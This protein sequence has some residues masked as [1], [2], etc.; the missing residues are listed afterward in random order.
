MIHLDTH[1][2][3]WLYAGDLSRFPERVRNAFESD[4]LVVS[5]A[6]VLETQYL[7]EIGR[8]SVPAT[9]VVEHLASSIG[10]QVSDAPFYEVI[11]EALL[12]SWTRDPFDRMITA[13][14]RVEKARLAT[15]DA[16]LLDNCSWAFWG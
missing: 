8:I 10:V 7:N 5:P 3:V 6:A 14:A 4:D 2:L 1:A 13:N 9:T 16:G 15:K 12:Q 11:T